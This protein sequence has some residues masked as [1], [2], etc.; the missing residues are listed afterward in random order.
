MLIIAQEPRCVNILRRK[1][2]ICPLTEFSLLTL[3]GKYVK[4]IL[5]HYELATYRYSV[6]YFFMIGMI[7]YEKQKASID[8]LVRNDIFTLLDG[9][10]G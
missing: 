3:H 2:S 6:F 8:F 9:L 4:I 10:L 7:S 1:F 5:I